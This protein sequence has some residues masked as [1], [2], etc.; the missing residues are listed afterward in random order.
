MSRHDSPLEIEPC[1]IAR[2]RDAFD[3]AGFTG[4]S[5]RERLSAGDTPSS[6]F[7]RDEVPRIVNRC[8][9]RE[10]F[11]VLARLFLVGIS[12]PEAEVR[13]ALGPVM[14]DAATLG[15]LGEGRGDGLVGKFRSIPVDELLLWA[16]CA[17]N[18]D[19]PPYTDQVM[20]VSSSTRDLARFAIPAAGGEVLDLCTGSS[21]LALHLAPGASRVLATDYNPRAVDVGMFNARFNRMEHVELRQGSWFE[22][23]RG[24]QFDRIVCSPPF[25]L[26]PPPEF[27]GGPR[28]L[29]M[30]SE[31]QAD[32]VSEMVVKGV[33]AHLRPG[34][35]GQV[36]VNWAHLRGQDW[37]A[38]LASWMEGTGCD[39]WALRFR[40]DDPEQYTSLWMRE[41]GTDLEA[42]AARFGRW[43]AYYQREGIEAVS[44]GLITLRKRSSGPCWFA[45][46]DA[47]PLLGLC[48]EPI[49]RGF[50]AR[51]F[52]LGRTDDRI[53]QTTFR[54]APEARWNQTY[55]PVPGGLAVSESVLHL[56][57][58]LGFAV[59]LN[60]LGIGVL[61]TCR[62]QPLA[63][64]FE[65]MAREAKQ[66]P[67]R[68]TA[69]ALPLVKQLIE[70]GIFLPGSTQPVGT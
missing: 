39:A 32:G 26:T 48:S 43:L 24:E 9:A 29:Y 38:R 1:R 20:S 66:D 4:P 19:P 56:T 2:L 57:S 52:L 55:Q 44:Y 33:A 16:E 42:A 64:G 6:S 17:W 3:A 14:D 60:P 67:A 35:F 5:I 41:I 47:P 61:T 10:P 25:V 15:L 13:A 65:R 27:G 22:P 49:V 31:F 70:R 28:V 69:A 63:A 34:G 23:V 46:D 18:P 30:S 51:D 8:P 36:L 58:G 54:L 40:T 21:A 68:L 11:G 53:L 45:V 50:A 7:S 12:V 59:P 37:R 62:D